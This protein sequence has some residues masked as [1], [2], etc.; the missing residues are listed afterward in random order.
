MS[1]EVIVCPVLL[2]NFRALKIV[3]GVPEAIEPKARS[4]L[5]PVPQL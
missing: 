1:S 4:V 3:P 5:V 2:V